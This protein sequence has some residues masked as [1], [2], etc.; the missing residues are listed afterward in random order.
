MTSTRSAFPDAQDPRALAPFSVDAFMRRHW[1]RRP[2]LMRKAFPDFQV[3]VTSA[4]VRELATSDEVESRL[5]TRRAARWRLAHGPFEDHELP[6]ARQRDWTVLVQGVDRHLDAAH[7]L[8]SRFRFLGDAR[9]DDLM[10]SIAGDGGGVG[11]HVDSYDVFLLQAEGRRRWRIAPPVGGRGRALTPALIPGLPLKILADFTPTETHELEPGDMLYLP[12]GWQ[13]EGVALGPCMTYSIGFRAPTRQEFLGAWLADRADAPGGA[14][15]RYRDG[16]EVATRR[17]ARL[18][19]ALVD[20][21]RGWASDWRPTARELDGFIGRFMTE[22]HP[23]VFFEAQAAMAP[24]SWCHQVRRNGLR[25]DRRSRMAYRQGRLYINGEDWALGAAFWR[26][27][28][29]TRRLSPATLQTLLPAAGQGRLTAAPAHAQRRASQTVADTTH[30]TTPSPA[31][32]DHAQ[33]DAA[34]I[35]QSWWEHGWLHFDDATKA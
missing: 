29:D 31:D 34:T 13:H 21:L 32:A 12:P 33:A 7:S 28:A 30:P 5:I 8:L 11:P 26:H 18:P 17:P 1:Q 2:Q 6:S 22:P 27:L 23:S 35:L 9:L 4:T 3:P 10:I 16:G 15:P 20:T 24:G 19:Q 25:L 14:D